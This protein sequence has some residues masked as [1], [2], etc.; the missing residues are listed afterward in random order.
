MCVYVD[1]QMN[2]SLSD[3]IVVLLLLNLEI[4]KFRCT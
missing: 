4:V 1:L 3:N 2:I